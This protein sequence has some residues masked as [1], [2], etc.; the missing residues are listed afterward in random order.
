M[1]KSK[2]YM[3]IEKK[4]F[5]MTGMKHFINSGKLRIKLNNSHYFLNSDC[6]PN[7]GERRESLPQ[8]K[9]KKYH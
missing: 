3:F 7:C 4:K 8:I 2:V 9:D 5:L 6:M 1:T